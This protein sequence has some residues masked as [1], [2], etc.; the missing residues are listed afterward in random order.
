MA[1]PHRDLFL[2]MPDFLQNQGMLFYFILITDD[3][4]WVRRWYP[5]KLLLY[6]R[7]QFAAFNFGQG[8]LQC[9]LVL[10]LVILALDRDAPPAQAGNFRIRIKGDCHR[11]ILASAGPQDL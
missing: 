1:F 6:I 3:V 8:N 4:A 11:A 9:L 10:Y 5:Q 7:D 2:E